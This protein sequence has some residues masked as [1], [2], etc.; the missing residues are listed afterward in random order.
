MLESRPLSPDRTYD[1]R[2]HIGNAGD[3]WKHA[4]WLAL[5]G[6]RPPTAGPL[7]IVETHAGRGSYQRGPTGEW[8][9]GLGR[10]GDAAGAP[11][12]VVR[13][14][15]LQGCRAGG[16]GER[17]VGSPLVTASMLRSGD[18]LLLHERDADAHAALAAAVGGQAG[19]TAR[20]SDGWQA[21]LPEGAG[22]SVWFIDPPFATREEWALTASQA[23]AWATAHTR[24]TVV[25]WYPIKGASRP[26]ALVRALRASG[27]PGWFGELWTAPY[28]E[29]RNRLN[30]SGMAVLRPPAGLE[31]EVA[32]IGGW[33]GPRLAVRDG[34]WQL[35]MAGWKAAERP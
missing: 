2:Y 35:K 27:L 33:L 30:G 12:A 9:E 16:V 15:E 5:L 34:D 7:T 25:I 28:D 4:V 31:S 22:R 13:L 14:A 1:H 19:V 24:A 21:E 23:I 17:L 18:R 11:E 3:V 8:M 32:A 6:S 26:A 10:L 29:G 20:C